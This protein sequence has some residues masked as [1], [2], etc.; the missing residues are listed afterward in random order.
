VAQ[1]YPQGTGFAF[2]TSYD[3]QGSDGGSLTCLHA[4]SQNLLH[5]NALIVKV[6]IQMVS[7]IIEQVYL[8]TTQKALYFGVC[9]NICQVVYL[10]SQ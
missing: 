3:S 4:V 8:V 10:Q 9:F 1:L 7:V 5:K 6:T 2:F